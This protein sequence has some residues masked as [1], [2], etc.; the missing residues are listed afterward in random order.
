MPVVSMIIGIVGLALCFVPVFGALTSLAA[1]IL[2]IVCVRKKKRRRGMTI[3][4]LATGG[5]GIVAGTLLSVAML[6]EY[7]AGEERGRIGTAQVR[8]CDVQAAAQVYA[9]NNAGRCPAIGELAAYSPSLDLRDP[10]GQEYG[11]DCSGGAPVAY[12][13]APSGDGA[14]IVC[15]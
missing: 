2:G 10:W 1:V 8:A 3:A 14:P 15:E 9:A 5:A 4:G 12:T 13:R 11:I 7:R 6:V